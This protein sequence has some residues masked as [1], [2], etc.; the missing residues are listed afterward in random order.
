MADMSGVDQFFHI[1]MALPYAIG[2]S[3]AQ[4]AGLA[5]IV[6]GA[7]RA[8]SERGDQKPRVALEPT[9]NGLRLFGTF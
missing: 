2:T 8:G 4:A 3:A 9:G 6:H 5:L 7:S 1:T